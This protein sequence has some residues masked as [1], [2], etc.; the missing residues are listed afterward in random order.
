MGPTLKQ[1]TARA[2]FPYVIGANTAKEASKW[3]TDYT[4]ACCK[5]VDLQPAKSTNP[6]DLSTKSTVHQSREEHCKDVSL[7]LTP[8]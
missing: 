2:A 7:V 8:S 6:V 5:M 3:E 4:L 1:S